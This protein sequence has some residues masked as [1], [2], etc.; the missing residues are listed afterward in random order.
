MFA[1]TDLIERQM[2]TL[3]ITRNELLLRMG[4]K[5]LS[6]GLERLD[7]CLRHGRCYNQL[8]RLQLTKALAVPEDEVNEAFRQTEE[9]LALMREA[10]E[11][12]SFRPYIYV[13]S[14]EHR[15]SF[16]TG[17]ALMGMRMKYL[18]VPD[19]I[20]KLL[21][22]A[23]LPRIQKMIRAHQKETRG[24][25]LLFGKITGYVYRWT[26][27]ESVSFATDGAVTNRENGRYQ[28]DGHASVCVGG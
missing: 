26:F 5:K 15:P 11:R 7:D 25:C 12:E 16:I 28:E 9:Q 19:A 18:P 17:A 8:F 10:K 22:E 4:Y 24:E 13:Q 3:G 21:L 14:S 27:E 6:K 20:T 1:I 2:E 23:Q